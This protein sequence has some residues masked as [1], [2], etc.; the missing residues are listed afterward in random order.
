MYGLVVGVVLELV[1]GAVAFL[2]HVPLA[3]VAL[4][5]IGLVCLGVSGDVLAGAARRSRP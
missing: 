2:T 3:A 1:A 4:S 5:M